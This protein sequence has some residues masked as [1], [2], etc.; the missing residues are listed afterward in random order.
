[1]P[2]NIHNTIQDYMHKL[3][4]KNN[5]RNLKNSSFQAI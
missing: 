3:L 1:M 4:Y 5:E 2:P